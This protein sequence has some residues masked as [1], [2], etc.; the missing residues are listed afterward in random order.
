MTT[1]EFQINDPSVQAAVD[2]PQNLILARFP[3]SI[4]EIGEA[5]EPDSVCFRDV[6]PAAQLTGEPLQA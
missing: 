6:G 4:F 1:V 3:S 2:V 5:E